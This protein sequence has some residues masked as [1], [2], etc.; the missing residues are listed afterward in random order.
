[1]FASCGCELMTSNLN[2]DLIINTVGQQAKDGV[3]M[4]YH[5]VLYSP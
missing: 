4:Y 3:M 2:F 1:L 5:P